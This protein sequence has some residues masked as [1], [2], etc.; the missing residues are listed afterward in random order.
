MM[1]S[2]QGPAVATEWEYALTD[3]IAAINGDMQ[4][5]PTPLD[6]VYI[7]P[8]LEYDYS[9]DVVDYTADWEIPEEVAA[10][11]VIMDYT[12]VGPT[13]PIGQTWDYG[14]YTD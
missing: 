2:A 9:G 14:N 3:L 6:Q 10:E 1:A 13:E 5:P 7:G 12:V 8:E 4:E 11:E